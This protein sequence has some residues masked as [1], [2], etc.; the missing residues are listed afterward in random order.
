MTIE[1]KYFTIA[2]VAKLTGLTCNKLR[3]IEKFNSKIN[4]IKIRERRYYTHDTLLYIQQL[5]KNNIA[6]NLVKTIKADSLII[7]IDTLIGKLNAVI[8]A[9]I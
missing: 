8:R 9:S 7:R 3:Y 1:K 6:P 2:E 5:Y 4:V